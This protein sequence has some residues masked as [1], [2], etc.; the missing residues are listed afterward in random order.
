MLLADEDGEQRYGVSMSSA[1]LD[2]WDRGR[3]GMSLLYINDILINADDHISSMSPGEL[4]LVPVPFAPSGKSIT[5]LHVRGLG[6]CATTEDPEKIAA[7][8]KFLRFVGSRRRAD[9]KRMW[10]M[11]TLVSLIQRNWHSMAILNTQLPCPRS[12]SIPLN[13][14]ENSLRNRMAKLQM[15]IERASKPLQSAFSEGAA[16]CG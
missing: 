11:D 4:G 1:S 12:G 8:W 6:V 13:S 2:Q 5:E 9:R 15:Y 14:L 16:H 10:K 3:I 7:S